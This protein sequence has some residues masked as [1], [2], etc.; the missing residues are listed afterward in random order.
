MAA[1]P[2]F[3]AAR[4]RVEAFAKRSRSRD[5]YEIRLVVSDPSGACRHGNLRSFARGAVEA[6]LELGV[7][8]CGK[9]CR[10]HGRA[11]RCWQSRNASRTL[12]CI[13][14][15]AKR[16]RVGDRRGGGDEPSTGALCA[17]A[18]GLATRPQEV[19]PCVDVSCPWSCSRPAWSPS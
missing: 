3:D 4:L 15:G 10:L 11:R 6:A 18:D 5:S 13:G 7:G 16:V 12:G 1:G 2:E 9:A 8:T 19:S 14:C 17:G